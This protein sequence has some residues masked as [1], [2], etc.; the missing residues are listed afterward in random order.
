MTCEVIAVIDQ[1]KVYTKMKCQSVFFIVVW[2]GV[3][4][5]LNVHLLLKLK[6]WKYGYVTV[7]TDQSNLIKALMAVLNGLHFRLQTVKTSF[8]FR[9]VI[10]DYVQ[11]K[12]TQ[13]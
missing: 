9:Y 11:K 6:I 13:T 10:I 3:G 1:S 5:I 4:F 7:I 8:F 2:I 12:Q